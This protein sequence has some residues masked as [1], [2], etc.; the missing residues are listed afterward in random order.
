M[1]VVLGQLI[2]DSFQQMYGLYGHDQN[3]QIVKIKWDALIPGDL[4]SW[5]LS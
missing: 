5:Y 4:R 2:V 1:D 3:D